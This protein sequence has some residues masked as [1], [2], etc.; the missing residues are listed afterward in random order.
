MSRNVTKGSQNGFSVQD[1]LFEEIL[2]GFKEDKQS[3]NKKV[4]KLSSSQKV[5]LPRV[6]E[7]YLKN[8]KTKGFTKTWVTNLSSC[9]NVDD[10][11]KR[12]DKIGNK[13]VKEEDE[14][15]DADFEEE[16]ESFSIFKAFRVLNFIRTINNIMAVIDV[17]RSFNTDVL[18]DLAKGMV[19][20]NDI[21]HLTPQMK[22]VMMLQKLTNF[23]RTLTLPLIPK[24][25]QSIKGFYDSEKIQGL[26]DKFEDWLAETVLKETAIS[27]GIWAAGALL[28][29][30]TG[31]TSLLAAHSA[32]AARWAHITVEIGR[33]AVYSYRTGST[34]ASVL[35]ILDFDDEDA[36]KWATNVAEMRDAY[37]APF[38]ADLNEFITE[39]EDNIENLESAAIDALEEK[40]ISSVDVG[41]VIT[42]LRNDRKTIN[43]LFRF[44]SN[45]EDVNFDQSIYNGGSFAIQDNRGG[46]INI[47]DTTL[48]SNWLKIM[49]Q[50]G[51]ISNQILMTHS[52]KWNITMSNETIERLMDENDGLRYVNFLKKATEIVENHFQYLYQN[53][54]VY[55]NIFDKE[56]DRIIGEKVNSDIYKK[57]NEAFI[58]DT[59]EKI[60]LIIQEIT[61][62][63]ITPPLR[64]IHPQNQNND[65]SQPASN[66]VKVWR[67]SQNTLQPFFPIFLNSTLV[68][69]EIALTNPFDKEVKLK[70]PRFH[71]YIKWV[72]FDDDYENNKSMKDNYTAYVGIFQQ[73]EQNSKIIEH[74][75][76]TE[77]ETNELVTEIFNTITVKI[78]QI[79]NNEE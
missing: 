77:K 78:N 46:V 5:R 38:V 76:E 64:P 40:I 54:I 71:E 48:T 43:K 53:I 51:E 57:Y 79:K 24:L 74:E 73:L 70:V 11:F 72:D 17:I 31:G 28:S 67:L 19:E 25:F 20:I 35:D 68:G 33:L 65:T 18:K 9:I 23:L 36:Q 7:S 1:Q 6:A 44:S 12:L 42:Q 30:I 41:G 22:R 47:N 14:E 29:K 66:N 34:I 63:S 16:K 15:D 58:D 3:T 4:V 45:F 13:R 10:L 49:H 2:N 37:I 52:K 56:S 69:F 59:G 61:G 8:V 26:F 75:F 50:E 21:T 39:F 27:I 62:K 60:A 55:F 32:S